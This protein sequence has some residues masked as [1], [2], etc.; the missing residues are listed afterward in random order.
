MDFWADAW[1]G[2]GIMQKFILKTINLFRRSD[3]KIEKHE[4]EEAFS[5]RQIKKINTT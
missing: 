4:Y 2:L 1:K 3:N 5:N